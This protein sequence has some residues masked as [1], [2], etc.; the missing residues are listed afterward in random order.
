MIRPAMLAL[1]FAAAPLQA[2]DPRVVERPFHE[3]A[4][5][6]LVADHGFQATIAFA[7]GEHVEN[8]AVGS[9]GAWQ[10]TPNRRADRVF[11]KPASPTAAPTNMTVITDRHTYLFS[12][13]AGH[14]GAPLYLLRFYYPDDPKP[15]PAP[16]PAAALAVA[17]DST[18]ADPARIDP[19]RLNFGWATSGARAILPERAYDDGDA[20]YLSWAPGRALPA[21]LVIGPDGKSEGLVNYTAKD[22][23]IIVEGTPAR[24]VLRSG[25]NVAY[26][27]RRPRP[28]AGSAR[29]AADPVEAEPAPAV[30]IAPT[31]KP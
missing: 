24:L 10:V 6:D 4:V 30:A 19:S 17:E 3:D 21:I 12:L 28:S 22:D 11:V 7:D 5:Y 23:T 15:E 8:I 31:R 27:D 25:K 18:R 16:V 13:R 2:A 14:K 20:V 9:S 29:P 1:L 26:L